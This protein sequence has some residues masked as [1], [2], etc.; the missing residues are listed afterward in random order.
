[1]G[2]LTDGRKLSCLID[3]HSKFPIVFEVKSESSHNLLHKIDTIFS[4]IGFPKIITTDNGPPFN[5]NDFEEYCK[6]SGITHRKITPEW[7]KA[8]GIA[9]NF[10]KTMRNLARKSFITG[11]D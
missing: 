11:S 7:V 8:N 10:V 1:M 4:L 3:I 6:Q 2:P 9:E 5:G